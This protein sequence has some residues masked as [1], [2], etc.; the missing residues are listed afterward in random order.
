MQ[1]G[2]LPNSGLCYSVPYPYSDTLKL[3]APDPEEESRL[4]DAGL[5]Y[6]YWGYEGLVNDEP[7]K[8]C[9]EFTVFRQTVTLFIAAI[10][11]ELP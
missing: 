4:Q 1:S 9:M 7:E 11:N 10:H 8:R 5:A 2:K 3:F 6:A